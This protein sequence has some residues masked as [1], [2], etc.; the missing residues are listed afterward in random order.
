M[1]KF[2]SF[3]LILF[4]ISGCFISCRK[5]GK[6][7]PPVLP[8]AATMLID[9]S[10]FIHLHGVS[11]N[12]LDIKGSNNY[13]WLEAAKIVS[14]WQTLTANL[15]IPISAYKAASG[16]EASHISGSKW[17][18]SYNVNVAG[19][20]YNVR[21]TGETSGFQV[22]WEMYISQNGSS[23]FKWLTGTSDTNGTPGKWVFN[24]SYT[25]QTDFLQID[26]KKSG[27]K[28]ETIKYTYLKN[29]LNK[30]AYIEYGSTSGNYNFYYTVHYYNETFG[31]FSDANIEW[32]SSKNG[33]IKSSD[34]MDGTW[35]C[36]DSSGI[37]A[38]C[39]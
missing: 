9:F 28:I 33:R 32:N 36:W 8:A 13:N 3:A 18:W 16:R 17:G 30:D 39:N 38:T 34:Y 27:K 29:G 11:G 20:T 5:K 21:L 2:I 23:E 19:A 12:S 22:N 6:G 24:E 1:K 14:S 25:S 26:W 7:N 15:S 10:D 4:L 37:D 35:K 31:K